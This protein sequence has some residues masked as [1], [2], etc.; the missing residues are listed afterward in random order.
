MVSRKISICER[1]LHEPER[2]NSIFGFLSRSNLSVEEAESQSHPPAAETTDCKSETDRSTNLMVLKCYW[3]IIPRNCINTNRAALVMRP[4]FEIIIF[5]LILRGNRTSEHSIIK[6][7]LSRFDF[8]ENLSLLDA[9]AFVRLHNQL[10]WFFI[11]AWTLNDFHHHHS[12]ARF[13]KVVGFW[14]SS[15]L[16]RSVS[17]CWLNPKTTSN[18]TQINWLLIFLHNFFSKAFLAF[19]NSNF[20]KF[21]LRKFQIFS[22]ALITSSSC[23][24]NEKHFLLHELEKYSIVNLH[25]FSFL[26]A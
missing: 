16:T 25:R 18:R 8:L 15:Y 26:F 10:R 22:S 7:D 20:S 11:P 6:F 24:P 13:D 21:H 9:I 14:I 19:I 17:A 3:P 4:L 2:G 23:W 12:E 1:L 5:S